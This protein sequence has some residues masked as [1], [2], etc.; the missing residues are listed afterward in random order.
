MLFRIWAGTGILSCYWWPVPW[1]CLLYTS[2]KTLWF[3]A[4]A[5]AF[6][7]LIRY[8]VLDWAPTYLKEVKGYDITEIGWAYFVYEFAAIP[9]T[10]VCGWLL[11]LIHIYKKQVKE[12]L[13]F[14]KQVSY[15]HG[16]YV[17]YN[18]PQLGKDLV[19]VMNALG[20]DVYK[21]QG[22]SLPV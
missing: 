14:P 9:G 5:N 17:N 2:N 16:C 6:I 3:I 20:I 10:I 13:A 7:Y 15:F 11:S 8:G 1:R 4:L 18:Y 21:R 22:L 19:K 12:Q